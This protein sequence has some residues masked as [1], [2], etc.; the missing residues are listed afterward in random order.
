M[1]WS[2]SG[3]WVVGNLDELKSPSP[4]RAARRGDA[5]ERARQLAGLDGGQ[6]GRGEDGAG[7][8]DQQ[9]VES[10]RGSGRRAGALSAISS[11]CVPPRSA[12]A[13][14]RSDRRSLRDSCD[15]INPPS[16]EMIR[17][18][19]PGVSNDVELLD[20]RLSSGLEVVG[21]R[22]RRWRR[23]A[24]PSGPAARSRPSVYTTIPTGMASAASTTS[25][26]A[27]V[28][29]TRRRRTIGADQPWKRKP[30][31]RIVTTID[32]GSESSPIF[33]RSVDTWVSSV[34]VE[35]H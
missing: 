5:F 28:D 27:I 3:M 32:G 1:I 25:T 30:T 9:D 13:R 22:A 23:A 18:P 12:T 10:A 31:P 21:E 7:G 14:P 26:M 11:I 35:P 20:V 2:I 33:L 16:T 6:P 17:R 34:R 4:K 19:S 8:E 24:P 29:T 15:T